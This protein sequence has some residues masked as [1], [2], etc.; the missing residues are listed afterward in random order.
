MVVI[1]L[2]AGDAIP[3]AITQV[4]SYMTVVSERESN[5]TRG[6]CE[7]RLTLHSFPYTRFCRYKSYADPETEFDGISVVQRYLLAR[8]DALPVQSGAVRAM[9]IQ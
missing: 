5:P 2:K 8:N 9:K 7:A 4:L 1:E 6:R 3:E